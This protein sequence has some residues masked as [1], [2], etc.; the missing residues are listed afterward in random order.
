VALVVQA[1]AEADIA[2]AFAWYESHR[3]GLGSR[4]L[5]ELES[6]LLAIEQEP[7]RFPLVYREVRRALLRQFPYAVFFVAC[8]ERLVIIAVMHAAR[9][10]VQWTSRS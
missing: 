4:F 2:E 8:S 3:K 1:A 7:A 9:E 10:P 6:A 5:D